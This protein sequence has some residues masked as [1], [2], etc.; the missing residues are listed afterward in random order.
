MKAKLLILVLIMFLLTPNLVNAVQMS[1]IDQLN[2]LSDEA[3]Q[4]VKLQRYED[5]KKILEYF[6]EEFTS[7]TVKERPFTMDELR[8]VTVAHDE[9][10]QAATN[11]SMNHDERMNRVTKLRLVMD[12]IS[13]SEQPLWTEMKNPI[14]SVFGG[15]K[16]AAISGDKEDFNENLNSFLSMYDTIYPSIK[17]DV[18][19]SRIQKLDARISFIDHYRYQVLS[20]NESKKE[21]EALETDLKT[22]FDNMKEDEADPSLWWVIISTG[23]I[24]ILTLSYVGWRKYIGDRENEKNRYR[25]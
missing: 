14:M 25:D 2:L 13:S 16:E 18:D 12:A 11:I 24:I 22:L 10:V 21:L 9:A 6:S 4:M 15:V 1:P 23:S 3:L 5:A 19:P 8:I 7:V 17:V 20:E